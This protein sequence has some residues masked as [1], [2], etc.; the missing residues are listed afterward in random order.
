MNGLAK[1]YIHVFFFVFFFSKRSYILIY[2]VFKVLLSSK[3][4]STSVEHLNIYTLFDR[5]AYY[6]PGVDQSAKSRSSNVTSDKY[7]QIYN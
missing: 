1:H 7:A 3:T 5:S 6:K 2:F 4:L